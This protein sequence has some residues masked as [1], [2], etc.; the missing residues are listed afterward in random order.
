MHDGPVPDKNDGDL[1]KD[2]MKQFLLLMLLTCIAF[3][4]PTVFPQSKPV[5]IV[6][7]PKSSDQEYWTF[8]RQ[9][10]DRAV[11]EI[12][13]VKL[14]W[15]GPTHNG[16]TDSQIKIAQLYIV[17]GVDAIIIAPTDRVRLVESA[18]RAQALNIKV[19]VVDSA[20]DGNNYQNFVTTNNYAAGELAAQNLSALLKA[21]G[22][23]LILRT[24]AESA[25]TE[26]RAKGFIDYL[27]KNS[28]EI[29]VIAD[30]YGGGSRGDDYHKA[31]ELLK[32][33]SAIDGIFAVNESTSDGVLRALRY[34]GLA[35]KIKFV[36]F[37]STD[38]L[39]DGLKKHEINGLV[40][41]DPRQMGYL[42]IKAAVA[43]V[44]NTPVKDPIIFTNSIFVSPENYR[45]PEIQNLLVP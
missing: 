16:D 1:L 40:I 35:G 43:A 17:P 37:D 41:Q 42:A 8:M 10:V 14:T 26:D 27:K 28:P 29:N 45:E 5:N 33:Y 12:G 11:R 39:L 25:S 23:V 2:D 3:A 13:N 44:K 36:G 31:M 4:A 38:F 34:T 21:H 9:G 15:R 30:E 20:L 22:N 32:N 18:Q 7:I 24:V 19:I 6:F